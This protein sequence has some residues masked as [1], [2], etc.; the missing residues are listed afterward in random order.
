MKNYFVIVPI[1]NEQRHIKI[2]LKKLKKHTQNIIIVND[3]STDKTLEIIK[4]FKNIHL[5]N[6]PRNKGKGTAMRVGAKFA[7]K[8][9]AEGIIF[10]DGDNQ[11]N[12]KYIKEFTSLL[13]K[14]KDIVIGVRIL[15]AEVP[16]YRKL[17]NLLLKNL[18]KIFFNV[19]IE[20]LICGYRGFSRKGYKQILW[21]SDGYGVE[22]EIMT[23]I[24]RKKLLF[25][26]IIVDTIYLEKYKGFSIKDGLKIIFK[27]PYW[28]VRS[29]S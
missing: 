6:L 8:L 28:R 5:I 24:G 11:H 15:K 14:G 2:F 3:G 17:G 22:T 1:Y 23:I 18:I 4:T 9:K 25:E 13:R 7:W 16:L 29:L 19:A 20:D 26:K 21:K 27:L 10:I 12:P